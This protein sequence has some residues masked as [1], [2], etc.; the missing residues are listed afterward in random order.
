[1][2]DPVDDTNST[3]GET[4]GSGISEAMFFRLL[5]AG[6]VVVGIIMLACFAGWPIYQARNGAGA[7]TIYKKLL[8][9]SIMVLVTGLNGVIFGKSA[10]TW[11]P[12]GD[13]NLSDIP[14]TTWLLLIANGAIC[15][16]GFVTLESYL[17]K[18]GYNFQ[19]F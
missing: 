1:M 10:F 11:F 6:A 16:Y 14:F 7:I 2:T 19:R 18:L 15:I 13:T 3:T 9:A 8:G 5:G 12:S 4:K 17:G